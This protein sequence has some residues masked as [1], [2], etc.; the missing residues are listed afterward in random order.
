MWKPLSFQAW[1]EEF[2]MDLRL[3]MIADRIDMTEA[4]VFYQRKYQSYLASFD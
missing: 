4:T 1:F 3:D 2:E